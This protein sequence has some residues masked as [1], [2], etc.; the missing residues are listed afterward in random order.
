MQM[1]VPV[2]TMN[3]KEKKRKEFAVESPSMYFHAVDQLAQTPSRTGIKKTT[4]KSAV[5]EDNRGKVDTGRVQSIY[6]IFV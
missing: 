1:L 2:K 5:Q 6:A 3:R 4:S